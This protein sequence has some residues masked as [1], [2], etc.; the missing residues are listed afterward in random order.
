MFVAPVVVAAAAA[1]AIFTPA[2]AAAANNTFEQS[3]NESREVEVTS[4]ALDTQVR[5]LLHVTCC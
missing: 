1:A 5:L 3:Y 2:A 4:A